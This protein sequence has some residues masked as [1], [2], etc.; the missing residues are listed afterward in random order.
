MRISVVQ[1]CAPAFP[2]IRW[3]GNVFRPRG[4]VRPWRTGR[5]GRDASDPPVRGPGTGSG[6]GCACAPSAPRPPRVATEPA[7]RA[8]R[9]FSAALRRRSICS[10]TAGSSGWQASSSEPSADGSGLRRLHSRLPTIW[11]AA[12]QATP[13]E[14]VGTTRGDDSGEALRGVGSCSPSH[15]RAFRSKNRSAKHAS[16]WSWKICWKNVRY[17]PALS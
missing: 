17:S 2:F 7:I 12:K 8:G 6:A 5:S 4:P 15:A 13:A 1:R 3:R 11:L 14:S 9:R 10:T 16:R